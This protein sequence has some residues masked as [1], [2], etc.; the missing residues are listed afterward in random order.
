MLP[1]ALTIA[2]SDSSAGA[3]VQADL[4]TFAAHGVYGTCAVTAIVAEVPGSVDAVHVVDL[5]L[6][7]AQITGVRQYFP[8]SAIKTGMLGNAAI[9]AAVVDLMS[10][11]PSIPLVIDPVIRASAGAALLD[12]EGL[13]VLTESLLPLARLVTPNIP[14]AEILLGEPIR[15]A[16]D[17]ASAPQKIHERYG[18]DVLVKG[19][20]F[21]ETTG[22]ADT[23]T[24]TIVD[25]AWI[26]GDLQRF[27]RPRLDVSDVH[28]T[29]CTLSAAIAA[30]LAKGEDLP[31]AVEAAT[32]YLAAALTQHHRWSTKDGVS[33]V[34]NHFPDELQSD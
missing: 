34:L 20:H 32:H 2:G 30:R 10:E 29:G 25:Y 5:A 22:T 1:I 15:N 7:R 3:G 4:K 14:E 18:C 33:E 27:S 24:D 16:A 17:F 26:D 13:A 31:S 19:G 28:G 12:E 21:F 11:N 23:T 6:L 9:V 8:I